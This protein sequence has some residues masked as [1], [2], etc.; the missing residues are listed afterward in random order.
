MSMAEDDNVHDARGIAPEGEAGAALH[1]EGDVL[2]VPEIEEHLRVERRRIAL[3]FV[4]VRKTVITE[5]VMIP[6][7]L[8]REVVEYRLIDDP[9]GVATVGEAP[10]DLKDD[11]VRIPVFREKAVVNKEIVV[12]SE[13]VI[14]RKLTAERQSL[15]ETLRRSTVEVTDETT[16]AVPARP[17]PEHDGTPSPAPG[18]PSYPVKPANPAE[19]DRGARAQQTVTHRRE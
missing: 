3:G 11:T 7:E 9:G 1:E 15:D 6:V 19:A 17:Y 10:G 18:E 4:E 16:P 5:Q 14:D 2:R 8:R 13:V 12:T